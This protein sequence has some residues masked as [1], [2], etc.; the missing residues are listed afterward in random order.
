[1]TL[2]FDIGDESRPKGHAVLY[3]GSSETELLATYAVL[4]PIKMDIGKY[5]PPM[6]AAQLGGAVGDLLGDGAGGFAVPPVP[7]P[8]ESIEW[9]RHLAEMRSDDLIWGGNITLGDMQA[10]MHQAAESVQQYA[11]MHQR[12]L[13]SNPEPV[14]RRAVGEPDDGGANVQHVIYQLMSDR[15]RLA[16]LSKL[17]GTMRFALESHDEALVKETD[18]SLEALASALDS[19]F[20]ADRVRYAAQ[21]PSD[22]AAKLAQLYVERCYKLL[23]EDF[24]TV[25]ALEKEIAGLAGDTPPRED[26]RA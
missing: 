12:Y 8:V 21:D 13:D 15:D 22:S 23:A 6:L 4:L 16:E 20:W 24:A 5:L 1:M 17:V 25:D 11:A 19:R 3:F 2:T 14:A 9:L 18:V 10:A 7:E 26:L